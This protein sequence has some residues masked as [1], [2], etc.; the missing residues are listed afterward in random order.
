[1]Q[2]TLKNM[3]IIKIVGIKLYKKRVLK[4]NII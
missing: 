1:M 2:T 4:L 3:L